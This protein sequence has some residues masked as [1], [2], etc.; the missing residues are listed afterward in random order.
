MLS[1]P[2]F[3][4]PTTVVCLD[5]DESLLKSLKKTIGTA[6]VV[7]NFSSPSDALSFINAYNSPLDK[8]SFV[9]SFAEHEYYDTDDNVPVKLD[10]SD[11]TALAKNP[12]RFDELSLMVVDYAMPE[13]QGD[14]VLER[15][16]GVPIKKMLFTGNAGVTEAATA[17]NKQQLNYYLTKNSADIFKE[18][19][20]HIGSLTQEFFVERTK[21]L[22]KYLEVDGQ[23]PLSDE[24]FVKLFQQWCVEHNIQE[25][26]LADKNGSFYLVDKYGD[27]FY[28]IVHTDK[29]LATFVEDFGE[30]EPVDAYIDQI[31]KHTKIPFFLKTG[32][33]PN[34][35][36]AQKWPKYLFEPN[37]LNGAKRYYWVAVSAN[38][39][40]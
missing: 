25:Y 35:I 2:V 30:D 17:F 21:Y 22:L 38:K 1:I 24:A 33:N 34:Q 27:E 11:I 19:K 4:Y 28:F 40:V 15:L 9:K 29:S 36:D 37:I 31:A 6:Y 10:I 23:L 16:K 7:K 3:Y 5:D 8:I 39:L 20:S 18:L 12:D 13:M 14:V 32:K 26:Y